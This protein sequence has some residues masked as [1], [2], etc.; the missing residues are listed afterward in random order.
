MRKGDRN[1]EIEYG[2]RKKR[3][4]KIKGKREGEKVEKGGERE[5]GR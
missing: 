4:A 1:M 3:G 2:K 5:F